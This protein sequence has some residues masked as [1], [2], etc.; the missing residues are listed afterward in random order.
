M[1]SIMPEWLAGA[2][3]TGII[4]VLAFLG[5]NVFDYLSARH[6]SRCNKQ[7]KLK[8]LRNLLQESSSIYCS[9][10]Y[11]ARQ[12]LNLLG[13]HFGGQV[14]TNLG[15]DEVFYR[16]YDQMSENE[17]E[18]HSLIRATTMN[19]MKRLN[20]EF[21]SWLERNRIFKEDEGSLA[22]KALAEK[23]RQLELHINQWHDKYAAII[24]TNEK[25]SLVYLA[26][27][28]NHGIGFPKDISCVL[29]KLIA[30]YE[31]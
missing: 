29:D 31:A 26:D 24:P 10:N 11:Q 4:G 13:K 30:E 6:K 18:L 12:L 22:Q 15:F 16:F 23:L 14:Q 7:D 20:G 1:G 9:Q 3:A 19:S 2:I 28:K 25:R 27:E 8:D 17:R 5:K 21:Q